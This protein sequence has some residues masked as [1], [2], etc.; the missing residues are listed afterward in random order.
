MHPIVEDD[1]ILEG[2]WFSE[3]FSD[4]LIGKTYIKQNTYILTVTTW[5]IVTNSYDVRFE[6]GENNMNNNS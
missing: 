4:V 5:C 3:Y 6:H 1:N 2:H